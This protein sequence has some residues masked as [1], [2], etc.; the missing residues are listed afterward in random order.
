LSLKRDDAGTL[1]NPGSI[2]GITRAKLERSGTPIGPL[3][4][5]IA[6]QAVARKLIL[7]T[8]NDR[9]FSRVAGRV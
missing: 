6:S 8:N 9:E 5:V 3:D 4:T 2:G 1:A 7:V